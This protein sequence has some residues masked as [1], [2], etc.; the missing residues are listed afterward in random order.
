LLAYLIGLF[1]SWRQGVVVIVALAVVLIGLGATV[2]VH[3]AQTFLVVIE[4]SKPAPHFPSYKL[5]FTVSGQMPQDFITADPPGIA[6]LAWRYSHP[7]RLMHITHSIINPSEATKGLRAL[8]LQ[9]RE[10]E[11]G[12]TEALRGSW[13]DTDAGKPH[14]FSL[15]EPHSHAISAEWRVVALEGGSDGELVI[16]FLSPVPS[17]PTGFW[18]FVNNLNVDAMM[19]LSCWLGAAAVAF[20]YRQRAGLIL[21]IGGCLAL[22]L[23]VNVV[24][25]WLIRVP[26]I[27]TPDS[28][29]YVGWPASWARMPGMNLIYVSLLKVL[30]FSGVHV[31]QVNM[32]ILSYLGALACLAAATIRYWPFI[33]LTILPMAWG[34]V[35]VHVSHVMSEPWFISGLLI[36]LS[37]LIA[38][39][40]GA[41]YK[42]AVWAS[43]GLVLTI[44][45]KPVAA[46]LV[47]PAF[48]AYRFI[49]GPSARRRQIV[50]ITIIPSMLAYVAMS[51]YGST[52]SGRFAPHTF[53]GISL[54]GY[55]AWMLEPDELPKEYREVGREAT[56][57]LRGLYAQ[58]PS[59]AA[60]PERFVDFNV[61]Q[62]NTAVYR[63]LLPRFHTR[64]DEL[65]PRDQRHYPHIIIAKADEVLGAWARAAIVRDPLRYAAN[66][67]LNYWALWRDVFRESFSEWSRWPMYVWG[68]ALANVRSDLPTEYNKYYDAWMQETDGH[69]LA[70]REYRLLAISLVDSSRNIAWGLMGVALATSILYLIPVHYSSAVAGMIVWALCVNALF[71]GHAL[72]NT[73][74]VR[75]AEPIVPLLPLLGGLGLLWLGDWVRIGFSAA[76][77]QVIATLLLWRAHS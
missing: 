65:T 20:F 15:Q 27:W 57:E 62:I 5:N 25:F 42:T 35:I 19:F 30:G 10:R 76:Q 14:S 18:E 64:I 6:F 17:P 34:N 39:V 38:L 31:F 11:G 26:L 37:G 63:I 21:F 13:P 8:S 69:V 28:A 73:T 45:T 66:C 67:L 46:V 29:S 41:G 55:I 75:Y 7:V 59:M 36:A 9:Y 58:Q 1:D 40:F 72:F 56:N 22:I 74:L 54:S 2:A 53:G 24:I 3:R 32:V 49:P 16:G 52:L 33:P 12:W 71:S 23:V 4:G 48:L 61:M 51:A 77:R 60:E 70:G 50:L 68:Y 43:S 47:L 44:C